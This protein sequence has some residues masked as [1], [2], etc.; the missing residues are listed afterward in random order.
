MMFIDTQSSMETFKFIKHSLLFFSFI[1]LGS[2]FE[3]V[4]HLWIMAEIIEAKFLESIIY[5][6]LFVFKIHRSIQ[7][8][9][10]TKTTLCV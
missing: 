1:S 7:G 3:G 2:S 6:L 4:E 10:S 8:Q 5:E 9:H